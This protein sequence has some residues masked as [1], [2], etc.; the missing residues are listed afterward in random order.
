M[1]LPDAARISSSN[2]ALCFGVHLC[3]CTGYVLRAQSKYVQEF[4]R[5]FAGGTSR[6]KNGLEVREK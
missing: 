3:E 4:R 2:P 5:N 1:T 6:V